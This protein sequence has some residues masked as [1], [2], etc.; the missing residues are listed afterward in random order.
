M[1]NTICIMGRLAADPEI[2]YT[3]NGTAV[4]SVSVAVER[5]IVSERT[6]KRECDFLPCV[7][8]GK[9]AEF[10]SKYFAKGR[11]IAVEGRVE[12]RQWEDKFEQRRLSIEI[13]AEGVHFCGDNNKSD[14]SGTPGPYQQPQTAAPPTQPS[15][16]AGYE[17]PKSAPAG[18]ARPLPPVSD[19]AELEDDDDRVPF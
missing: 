2:K 15:A 18:S 10:V 11:M 8:W 5:K 3:Q 1:L 9:T 19:F 7:F 17:K 4:V 12:T 6:G 14:Q 16:P 13:I